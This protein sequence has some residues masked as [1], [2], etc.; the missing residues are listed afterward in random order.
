MKDQL[1]YYAKRAALGL[2]SRREFVGRAMVLGVSAAVAGSMFGQAVQ[3]AEP[4]KGGTLKMGLVGGESTNSLDPAAAASQVP[5]H[6]LE[7]VRR[8]HRQRERVRR[9]RLSS[10]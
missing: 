5:Y 1:D 10:R 6:N 2:M 7:P 8:N 3:A 4:R 9:D